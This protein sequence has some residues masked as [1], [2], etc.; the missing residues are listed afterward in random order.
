MAA[1]NTFYAIPTQPTSSF[2]DI[3]P[4]SSGGGGSGANPGTV[5]GTGIVVGS[6]S[7]ATAYIELRIMTNT[8]SAATGL[9]TMNVL[10]ALR[11]L[12][13]FIMQRGFIGGS[14]G[15]SGNPPTDTTPV[16]QQ[17]V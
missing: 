3:G 2:A 11:Q 4:G 5:I 14:G 9:N 13:R 16:G 1:T 17:P 10:M 7:D 8:G 15:P 6:S 12:C